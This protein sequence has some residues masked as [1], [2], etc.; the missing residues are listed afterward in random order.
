[1]DG[2]R[3]LHRVLLYTAVS[4]CVLPYACTEARLS[5]SIPVLNQH[6]WQA[7]NNELRDILRPLHGALSCD[8]ISP[9]EAGDGLSESIGDFLLAKPEFNV[10][11][12]SNKFINHQS[13]K[14]E[15]AKN[16]K[17]YY[18]KRMNETNSPDDR[19]KFTQAVRTHNRLKK[20]WDKDCH[21]KSVLFQERQFKDNFW[22]FA[23]Q[24]CNGTY[25]ENQVYQAFP[26]KLP[27]HSTLAN[28]L[29]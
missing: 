14:V 4:F 26:L 10:K 1:M 12:A 6:E 21:E 15:N 11:N 24:S 17:K 8:L 13:K 28:I 25:G 19:K 18:R 29:I 23:K 22:T 3:I 9:A 7:Y 5:F 2:F 27:T 20:D 16:L